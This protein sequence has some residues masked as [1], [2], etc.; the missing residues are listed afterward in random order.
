MTTVPDVNAAMD[1][2]THG[3]ESIDGWLNLF[4]DARHAKPVIWSFPTDD[5][6]EVLSFVRDLGDDMNLYFGVATRDRQL[7]DIR[8]GKEDCLLLP[9]LFADIDVFDPE[10]H[11]GENN[12]PLD[13]SAALALVDRFRLRPTVV[14]WSGGGIHACWA[15]RPALTPAE[16]EPLLDRMKLTMFR[17]AAEQDVEIDNIF[18]LARMMRLPGSINHKASAV[19]SEIIS[20]DW[21]R[22]YSGR[23]FDIVL[24]E[25][26]PPAPPSRTTRAAPRSRLSLSQ[27]RSE[28]PERDEFNTSHSV[29]DVLMDAGWSVHRATSQ[30]TEYLRPDKTTVGNSATVFANEPERVVVWSNAAGVP[31]MRGFD[32]WGLHVY[33]NYDGDFAAATQVGAAAR[34]GRWQKRGTSQSGGLRLRAGRS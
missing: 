30:K 18:E 7:F 8:G 3:Y 14:V 6:S 26:P 31:P 32:A 12:Y 19:P 15:I 4:A 10:R 17:L 25:L 24:D 22:I 1:F 11:Q 34:F 33:L 16:A 5:L 21:G 29:H 27:T 23:D 20:C 2:L 28:W 9:M 13:R